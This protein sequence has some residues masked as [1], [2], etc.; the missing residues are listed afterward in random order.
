MN[1][2][3]GESARGGGSAR[4]GDPEPGDGLERGGDEERAD[5][6]NQRL[7]PRFHVDIP[8]SCE[9]EGVTRYARAVNLS[10]G[11]V[12][13]R[14]ALPYPVG[15]VARMTF[16]L[17]ASGETVRCEGEIRRVHQGRRSGMNV[18][19]VDLPPD[20]VERLERF[21]SVRAGSFDPDEGL[22]SRDDDA[23][24]DDPGGEGPRD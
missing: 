16:E 17:P 20:Q 7:S 10:R 9:V 13:L 8:V 3:D 15:A 24:G 6:G 19:F 4:D 18:A 22:E 21:L 5:A 11:G 23:S 1:E 14:S 12:F 2:H